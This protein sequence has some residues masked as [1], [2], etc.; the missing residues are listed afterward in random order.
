MIEADHIKR[1]YML[2]FDKLRKNCRITYDD[3]NR[4]MTYFDDLGKEN[5]PKKCLERV[6]KLV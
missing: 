5:F 3:I 4:Q 6:Q 1:H 2:I